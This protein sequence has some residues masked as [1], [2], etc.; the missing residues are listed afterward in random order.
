MSRNVFKIK[1]KNI[2]MDAIHCIKS[3]RS[4]RIFR[5]DQIPDDIL[6]KILEAATWAPSSGNLQNWEFVVVKD[7]GI[8]ESIARNCRQDFI[9][10]APVL[11]V[12]CSNKKKVLNYGKRGEEFFGIQNTSAA[13]QNLLLAAHSLGLGTCWVGSFDEAGLSEILSLPDYV[14]PVAVIPM[15]YPEGNP[16]QTDRIPA[17]D[18]TFIDKYQK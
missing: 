6:G 15:G 3:R 1:Q 8:R 14:Q 17:E 7:I 12:V 9:K 11:I 16:R 18:V 4:V 13:V 10:K 2:F 5:E